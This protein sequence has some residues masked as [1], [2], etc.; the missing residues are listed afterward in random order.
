MRAELNQR[1][2]FLLEIAAANLWP[3][4]ILWSNSS[5]TVIIAELTV[6]WEESIN[7]VFERKI[8]RYAN[9]AAEAEECSWTAKVFPVQVGCRGFVDDSTT[10]LSKEVGIGGQAKQRVVK[11]GCHFC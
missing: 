11:E 2:S 6:H 7:K 1:L 4:T 5:R 9:L 10:R 8:L 3:D